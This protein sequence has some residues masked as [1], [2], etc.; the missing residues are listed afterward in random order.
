MEKNILNKRR[1]IGERIAFG[2]AFI[3]FA[4]YSLSIILMFVWVFLSSLKSNR[5]FWNEPFG[6][7]ENWLFSNYAEAFEMLQYKGTNFLGM[8]FNSLWLTIGTQFLSLMMCSLTGYVFAKYNF[9]LKEIMYA[10]VLFTIIVPILS[11]GA[12]YYR[13]IYS[14]GL[15]D[16][17]LYLITALGGFS[18]NFIIFNGIYK[19]FPW[20][21]AEAS[22]IDGGGHF[23]TYFR[24]MLPMAFPP[25]LALGITGFISGWNDY[26]TPLMYLEQYPTLASGLYFYKVESEFASNEPVYLAGALLSA[27]PVL[28]L[29]ALFQNKVFDKVSVGG[30]KG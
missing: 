7:P 13:L 9:K 29:F 3:I 20:S 24:I 16:S 28:I 21:Y 5:E 1:S 19:N 6:L 23:Y 11:S 2:I 25:M 22:F 18:M 10:I 4:L 27:L 30:L 26:M 12:S 15:N 17:P 14:L 8:I